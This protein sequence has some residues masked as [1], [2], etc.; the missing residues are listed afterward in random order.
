M[1]AARG[2]CFFLSLCAL[3][4]CATRKYYLGAVELP[5]DYVSGGASGAQRSDSR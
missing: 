2:L 3:C 5:W 4:S 1:R